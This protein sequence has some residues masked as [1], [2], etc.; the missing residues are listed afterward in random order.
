MIK[1]EQCVCGSFPKIEKKVS[2]SGG[3]RYKSKTKH[4]SW[5]A[6]CQGC[7]RLILGYPETEAKAIAEWNEHVLKDRARRDSED[8]LIYD[9]ENSYYNHGHGAELRD[10]ALARLLKDVKILLERTA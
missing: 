2:Y 1:V 5:E 8:K 7:Y 10:R 6:S 4:E 3:G 9:L